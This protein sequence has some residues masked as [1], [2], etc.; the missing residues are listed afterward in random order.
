MEISLFVQGLFIGFVVAVPVG[1]IGLLCVNRLLSGGAA[2]GLSSGLGIAAGDALAAAVA[3]LGLIL[4]SGFLVN[5]Q[6]WLRLLSGLF[7][8]YL[9]FRTFAMRPAQP[10]ISTEEKSLLGAFTTMF[11]LTFSNPVT[12]LSFIAIYAGLGVEPLQGYHLSAAVLSSGVFVGSSLWWFVLSAGLVLLRERFTYSG[13]RWIHR[14]SGVIIAGFG[15]AV[16]LRR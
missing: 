11:I 14:V 12:V 13:L 4:I 16:L 5:E 9:G 7:L 2:Y 10:G 8:F 3:A 1:P 6:L 15:L